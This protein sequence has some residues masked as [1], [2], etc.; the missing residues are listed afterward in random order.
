MAIYSGFGEDHFKTHAKLIPRALLPPMNTSDINYFNTL[1]NEVLT[2]FK[3][4]DICAEARPFFQ[5]L[6]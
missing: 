1:H 2:I 5:G 4:E 6:R 3:P